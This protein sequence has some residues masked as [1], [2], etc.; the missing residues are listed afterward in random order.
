MNRRW[1]AGCLALLAGCASIG[2]VAPARGQPADSARVGAPD[3][4]RAAPAAGVAATVAYRFPSGRERFA[5]WAMN[6][7]GFYAVAGDVA[8]AAY[9]QWV[10][11]EPPEWPEGGEG[12]SKRFGVA[13]AT[14]AITETSFSLLSAA[15]RQDARYY[16]CPRTGLG[17]R[18]AHAVRMTFVA[19]RP[20]GSAA[21]SPAKTVAPFVGPLVTR[22]TL[23]PD[24]YDYRDGALSGAYA[25]LMNLGWNVARE[26]VL[27]APRW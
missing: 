27:G 19:R 9:E 3:S 7:F 6:A 16:R 24:R 8:S 20:D 2:M 11:E 12:L 25:L 1:T 10:I 13:A 5:D 4:A 17:P 15:C 18:L 22:T 23:Y 21:F 26:F 14:T